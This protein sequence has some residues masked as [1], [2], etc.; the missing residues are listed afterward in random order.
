MCSPPKVAIAIAQA[1]WDDS[2]GRR[3]DPRARRFEFL[4]SFKIVCL[5]K[6]KRA[7]RQGS[8]FRARAELAK[9]SLVGIHSK[10]ARNVFGIR[11]GIPA[12]RNSQLAG[13]F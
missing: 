1:S 2:A 11:P 7:L 5:T 4:A 9:K 13:Y 12:S 8:H 10:V 3:P 6:L